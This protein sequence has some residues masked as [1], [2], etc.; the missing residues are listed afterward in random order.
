[1]RPILPPGV[2]RKIALFM[3]LAGAVGSLYFVLRA[4]QRNHSILLVLL[5]I[6]WVLSPFMALMVASV[7]SNRWSAITRSALYLLIFILPVGSIIVY[8]G[9]LT[10]EGTR[11][12][13]KFLIG[14]LVSWLLIAVVLLI[15]S[16]IRR[17]VSKKAEP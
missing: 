16:R 2:F 14:P 11:P 5:F 3:M 8:S 6:F 15:T 13:F 17:I 10:I 12:A 7:V 9:A 4:G 1:V